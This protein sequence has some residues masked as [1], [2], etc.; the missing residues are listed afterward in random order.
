MT[1]QHKCHI[2]QK[3]KGSQKPELCLLA[4]QA[5]AYIRL[6]V[7]GASHRPQ[8][9]HG[10]VYVCLQADNRGVATG[11]CRS[12]GLR[13]DMQVEGN[14]R[15]M[16]EAAFAQSGVCSTSLSEG[17]VHILAVELAYSFL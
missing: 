2:D 6:G 16:N 14:N 1:M 7:K 11:S 15:K 12:S 9:L 5:V 3:Q 13:A 4:W 8:G 10:L 17:E